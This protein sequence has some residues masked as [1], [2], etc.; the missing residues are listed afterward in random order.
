MRILLVLFSLRLTASPPSFLPPF[1]LLAADGSEWKEGKEQVAVVKFGLV[2]DLASILVPSRL[3]E[4]GSMQFDCL[5]EVTASSMRG[6]AFAIA[7]RE[8]VPRVFP[9]CFACVL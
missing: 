3:L 1:L 5:G 2:W 7:Y 8:S 4:F 9:Q 6:K